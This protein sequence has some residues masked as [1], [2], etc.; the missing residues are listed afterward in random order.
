VSSPRK[1]KHRVE[2]LIART[3]AVLNHIPGP[4]KLLFGGL[5]ADR[6]AFRSLAACLLAIVATN[7]MPPVISLGSAPIEQGLRQ[8]GSG[9]PIL[10][11]ANYLLLAILTLAAGATGDGVGRKPFLLIGLAGVLSAGLAS[12]FW[13]GTDGFIYA[14]LLLSIARITIIPMCIAIAAVAFE[15]GVRPFAFGAIFST[16]AIALGSSSGIY[17][18]LR[19]VGNGT[20]VYLLPIAL[21]LIAF[22]LIRRRV[23]EPAEQQRIDWRELLVNL[24]WAGAVF[25]AVYGLVAYAGGLTSRNALLVIAVGLGGLILAYRYFYRKL[26]RRGEIKLYNG[27]GLAFAILAGM[28]L[29]MVQATLFYQFWS[30]F[31]DVRRLG[32]VA[33]TLQFAPFVVGMLVGTLLI[34][35]L[36]TRFGARRL[37]AGGLV[38][39]ALGLLA[40]SRI[41]VDTPLAFLVLPIALLGLGLG[42]SGPARTSVIISAPPPRLIGSGAAIN[43][44]AGQSGYALGV[45][46]SSFL[47]TV[48]ADGALRAR[49]RQASLPG[50]V[51]MQIESA[52]K[53]AF[54]RALSGTYT[55]LPP[56]AAQWATTQFGP[57]FT[58]GL[59]QTLLI[60]AGIATVAAIFILV[61][62]PRGLQGSLITPQ[63]TSLATP[64][65]PQAPASKV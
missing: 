15:P 45:I 23:D 10:V 16:Q 36:S 19:H 34:V 52:W 3:Q 61:G 47:V 38:L 48:L 53:N 43:S 8:V 65:A 11:A 2:K 54:A 22:G 4:G 9:V 14:D 42:I 59:A 55:G 62:M 17:S 60:M 49:L 33:T 64:E 63:Q 56:E 13:L 46:V 12:M 5:T 40:L 30:Y 26:R 35:R 7:L 25:L 41:Q 20:I 39:S 18:V 57:A 51:M 32:P 29:A 50:D 24:L 1:E 28:T 6:Q 27:R 44:A 31:A 37:I 21:G 58:S